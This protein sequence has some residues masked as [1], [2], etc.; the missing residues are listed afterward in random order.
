MERFLPVAI[1]FLVALPALAGEEPVLRVQKLIITGNRALDDEEVARAIGHVPDRTIVADKDVLE[2]LKKKLLAAYAERG[3]KE[4]KASLR[5]ETAS[6]PGAAVLAIDVQEGEPERYSRIVV[7]GLPRGLSGALLASQADLKPGVV[8]DRAAVEESGRTLA[9]KLAEQ[10]YLDAR[11]E[12]FEEAPAGPRRYVLTM[13]VRAGARTTIIFRGNRHLRRGELLESLMGGGD[14]RTAPDSLDQGLARLRNLY[15]RA[16]FLH[17]EVT[18]QRLC[19]ADDGRTLAG[20]SACPS[21]WGEQR[22]T[23]TVKEGPQ[24]E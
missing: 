17:A 11:V 19:R 8:R 7:K 13:P 5:L 20:R 9:R 15:R 4:A 16:G 22:L 2:G 18:A 1:A 12:R 14:F 6:L 3:Y 10:G 23:F 21:G 24:V